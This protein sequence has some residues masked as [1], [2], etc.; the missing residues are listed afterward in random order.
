MFDTNF[1]PVGLY[2]EEGQELV[3]VNTRL[4]SGNFHM[5]PNGVFFVTGDR[6]GVL[7]TGAYLKQRVRPDIA[8]Q[9]GPMLVI[10]GRLHPRFLRDGTSRK[11]RS[12][13][14]TR[15]NHTAVFA[16]S[17]RD[18]SF[19]KFGRLFRDNLKCR[20]ALFLDGGSIPSLYALSIKRSG[21]I[22]PIGPM[23]GVFARVNYAGPV[24]YG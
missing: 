2:V 10:N 6:L 1:K 22:L 7:E 14:G 3:H 4:G 16:V 24:A 9:S 23:I 12:G 5:K 13:I 11:R 8:T 15:D 17:D 20:N 18:V 19:E 21:N